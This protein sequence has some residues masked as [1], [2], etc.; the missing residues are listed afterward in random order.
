MGVR[1][2]GA[3]CWATRRRGRVLTQRSQLTQAGS[4]GLPGSGPA[5]PEHRGAE[6]WP[7]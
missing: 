1:M 6:L 5:Q 2:P 3:K 7:S 4:G